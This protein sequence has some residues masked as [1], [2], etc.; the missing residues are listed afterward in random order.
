MSVHIQIAQQVKKHREAQRTFRNLDEK[1]E[2]AIEKVIERAKQNEEID[3][4]EINH[5]T[6]EMNAIA[7]QY[8][9]PTRKQVTIEMIYTYI[10]KKNNNK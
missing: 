2:E 10:K 9:F 6:N 7:A 8:Q 5:I 4:S 3:V 1:R